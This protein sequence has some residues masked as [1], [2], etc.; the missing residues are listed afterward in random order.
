MSDGFTGLGKS[1]PVNDPVSRLGPSLVYGIFSASRTVRIHAIDNRATQLALQRL[2]ETIDELGRIEGHITIAVVTDLL[3]INEVRLTVDSQQ[4]GPV[5]FLTE[6]MKKRNVEEIEIAPTIG[7]DELGRFLQV[8]FSDPA[9][10]DVFGA[11]ARQVDDAG[12][13]RIK[14]TERI[15]RAKV[16]RDTRID[17]KSIREESNKVMSRAV[18][19][20]GEVMRA[21]EQKHPIQVNKALRLT[22]KMADIMQV[23]ES[24]LIGLTS[25]KDYDEYTFAHSVNVCVLSMVIADRVGLSKAEIAEIG[26]AGLL[27]DI[28]KMHV[29]LSVLNK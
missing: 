2:R 25:I 10:D 13:T 26:V 20:M 1:A 24:V 27:H 18:L 7:D 16:L 12:I 15:E 5:L 3:A 8:F 6:E 29:P 14:L 9:S 28:G 17:K 11:L 4:M 19:F 23:D 21:I 22:Q